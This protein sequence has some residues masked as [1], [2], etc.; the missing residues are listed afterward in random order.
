[1]VPFH[2][3]CHRKS[4]ENVI[5]VVEQHGSDAWWTLP[6]EQLLPSEALAKVIQGSP[7]CEHLFFVGNLCRK[8]LQFSTTEQDPDEFR[9]LADQG[10]VRS[11]L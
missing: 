6:I 2:C 7:I 9:G 11:Y 5:K 10:Y 8:W 4:I 1:M 3:F